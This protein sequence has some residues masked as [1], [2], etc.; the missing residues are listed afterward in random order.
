MPPPPHP[1]NPWENPTNARL[2]VWDR[3]GT[4]INRVQRL[5]NKLHYLVPWNPGLYSQLLIFVNV[6]KLLHFWEKQIIILFS[7]NPFCAAL[8]NNKSDIDKVILQRWFVSHIWTLST[9]TSQLGFYYCLKVTIHFSPWL[10]LLLLVYRLCSTTLLSIS[11]PFI[12]L[13]LKIE[14]LDLP[15]ILDQ[16]SCGI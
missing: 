15:N 9:L 14:R 2:L 16:T 8:F 1:K 6:Q 10:L 7:E 4:G 13:S 11:R 3:I 5:G 12:S